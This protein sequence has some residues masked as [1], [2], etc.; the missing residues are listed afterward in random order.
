MAEKEWASS[1]FSTKTKKKKITQAMD[2][3]W[4]GHG[5]TRRARAGRCGVSTSSPPGTS[6]PYGPLTAACHSRAPHAH[7]AAPPS[8]RALTEILSAGLI[9]AEVATWRPPLPR[10]PPSRWLQQK[11][12]THARAGP[13]PRD[14]RARAVWPPPVMRQVSSRRGSA[15]SNSAECN[16]VSP[17]GLSVPRPAV[18]SPPP[19][20]RP[21]HAPPSHLAVGRGSLPVHGLSPRAL[22]SPTPSAAHDGHLPA[23]PRP[24]RHRL[25]NHVCVYIR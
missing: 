9:R 12:K 15:D 14:T 25:P 16:P 7:G 11:T 5:L 10:A 1:S 18:R 8:T 13:D 3:L 6:P 21:V 24:S 23:P 19:W 4:C 17:P 20:L 2:A 22:Y